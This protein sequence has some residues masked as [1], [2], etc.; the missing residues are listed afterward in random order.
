MSF[1]KNSFL[2][3]EFEEFLRSKGDLND[4]SIYVYITTIKQFLKRQPNLEDLNDYNQFLIENTR[5]QKRNGHYYSVIKK[6]IKWYVNDAALKNRILSNLILPKRIDNTK[7][8]RIYL[9]MKDM[10]EILN[11][12]TEDKNQIVALIQMYTG[13]RAGDILRLTR[14]SI[15]IETYKDKPVLRLNIIGKRDKKNVV[16]I[17]DEFIQE[18]IL[19]FIEE[20]ADDELYHPDYYFYRYSKF[21][22]RR[23]RSISA[24]HKNNYWKYW[25]DLKQSLQSCGIN[26]D[27]F[28]THDFRRC[29]A[30]RLWEKKQDVQMLQSAL[31]HADPKTTMRYLEQSGMKN[32]EIHKMMQD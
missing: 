29:F 19:D 5:K 24:L 14:G 28:A 27:D 32:I 7:R 16:F 30:R 17:H 26:R 1:L 10:V 21:H 4:H 31:N 6:F 25:E 18:Q 20:S 3:I 15:N 8:N 23:E 9:E 2:P 13:V 22:K 12:F 11:S